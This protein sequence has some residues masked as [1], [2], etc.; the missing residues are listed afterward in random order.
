M[1]TAAIPA[2]LGCIRGHLSDPVCLCLTHRCFADVKP[3]K[4]DQASCILMNNMS[5]LVVRQL[6]KVRYYNIPTSYAAQSS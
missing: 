2:R 5:E 4:F 3:R 1:Y 6:E